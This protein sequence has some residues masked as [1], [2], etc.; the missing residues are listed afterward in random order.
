MSEFGEGINS[1]EL[2]LISG[3]Y[4]GEGISIVCAE[5]FVRWQSFVCPWKLRG[6]VSIW[7]LGSK[8]VDLIMRC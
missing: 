3:E 5:R 2:A 7:T 6:L 8:Q 1:S 4:G